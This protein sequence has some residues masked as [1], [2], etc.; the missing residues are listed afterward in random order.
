MTFLSSKEIYKR[1]CELIAKEFTKGN[2]YTIEEMKGN[3]IGSYRYRVK[4]KHIDTVVSVS[5]NNETYKYE[6]Y[7]QCNYPTFHQ[8]YDI[9]SEIT[10]EIYNFIQSKVEMITSILIWH[11]D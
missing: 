2:E 10:M 5:Y 7:V 3:T 11:R 9:E 1:N 8:T 4:L 6:G